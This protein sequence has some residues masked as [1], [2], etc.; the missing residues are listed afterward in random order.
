MANAV[1]EYP[2]LSSRVE[3]DRPSELEC[4]TSSELEDRSLDFAGCA[5]TISPDRWFLARIATHLLAFEGNR[6]V[7]WFEGNFEDY[8]NDKKRRLGAEAAEPHRLM[9]KPLEVT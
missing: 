6:H 9:Y 2:S 5:S 8:E 4:C 1:G 7:G 3:F